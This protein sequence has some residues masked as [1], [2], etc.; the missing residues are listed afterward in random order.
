M[1][2]ITQI[3]FV[4]EYVPAIDG[5]R[6]LAI[7]SVVIYH[8][9]P[10]VMPGGFTGV[11]I[12]FVISGYLITKHIN[13]NAEKDWRYLLSFYSKR[14]RRILPAL[15]LVLLAT[16]MLGWLFLFFDEYAALGRQTFYSAIF[17]PNIALLKES[18]YFDIDAINKPL[19]NLWSLGIEEQFYIFWPIIFLA[20]KKLKLNSK[21]FIILLVIASFS[22]S[23][24]IQNTSPPTAFYS[25][26]SRAWELLIGCGLA[27]GIGAKKSWMPASGISYYL[28]I[29]IIALVYSFLF[30]VQNDKYPGIYSL[31]PTLG[32]ALII[33]AILSNTKKSSI[34]TNNW[35]V[36]VGLISY[37]LYL[38]HWPILSI[39]KIYNGGMPTLMTKIILIIVSFLMAIFTRS[40][41]EKNLR[42]RKGW[43]SIFLLITSLW[44]VGI[45]GFAIYKSNGYPDRSASNK[46][47]AD[48]LNNLNLTHDQRV[49]LFNAK[50]CRIAD[51]QNLN[52]V[53]DSQINYC[54]LQLSNNPPNAVVIGDSHA[55]DKFY[56][57]SLLDRSK[58]WLLL[59]N[60]ACPLTWS[61]ASSVASSN[62]LKIKPEAQACSKKFESIIKYI[63]N[64]KNIEFV[65]ISFM[66]IK[67]IESANNS[68]DLRLISNINNP[69]TDASFKN[70]QEIQLLELDY[71][72]KTLQNSG[73]KI[74]FIVVPTS[75]N[76]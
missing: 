56:G 26:I 70:L 62:Q 16:L 51:D 18:G 37:P 20:S 58:S 54:L 57:L 2:K 21:I 47:S 59:G 32:S 46:W 67:I 24:F 25:P 61:L 27:V 68:K 39:Y 75:P 74:I 40:C 8:Y 42:Y 28:P 45:T 22:Y 23:N 14:I 30:V 48:N 1:K 66:Q 31:I 7:L 49:T 6:A 29:G 4:K 43:V 41:I 55:E 38:W 10:E 72:F 36:Y 71:L 15:I 52:Q 63:L 19:L 5:L 12:F 64:N 50:S 44:I 53:I 13:D 69:F 76:A 34:L 60:S 9:F 11:D 33:L 73:K 3:N 35:L 65:A 17:I